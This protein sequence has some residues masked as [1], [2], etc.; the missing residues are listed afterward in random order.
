MATRI[1]ALP[2]VAAGAL[3][4]TVAWAL[5][6]VAL[7][8]VG[9]PGTV[10]GVTVFDGP[11]AAPVPTLLVALTVNVYATPLVSPGTT[12]GDAAPD[13]GRPPGL[14]VTV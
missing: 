12:I 6:A 2:P 14:E 1:G 11:E 4:T 10:A 13:A 9:A 7:G 5:P 3:K 8:P